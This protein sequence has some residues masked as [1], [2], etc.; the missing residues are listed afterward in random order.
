MDL[1]L[2]SLL[3][4]SPL[5]VI[6][7]ASADYRIVRWSNEATRLFGWT[8]EEAVGK[9]IDELDWIY[10]EDRP[11][12]EQ[13]MADMLSGRR[14]RNVNRNRNVRKDGSVI[15]CEWYNS[16]L[17]DESGAF[18]VLSLVLDVTERKRAEQ[19]LQESERRFRQ[20]FNGMTEGFAL[21]EV[22]CNASATPTDYR[23]LDLN[24]A[25]ERLTG[26]RRDDVIGKTVLE[27]LPGTDPVWIEQ[28]GQVALT[29]QPIH[30]DRYFPP[31]G[32]HYDVFAYSP[33]PRQFAVLFLDIT[34]RKRAEDA[35]RESEERYRA[36]AENSP[37][38]IIRFDRDLRLLFA[39]PATQR[40][41]AKEAV[42]LKG[43]TAQEYGATPASAAAW[44][45]AARRALET[46][47]PQRFDHTSVWG[48]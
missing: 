3:E 34:E 2:E 29:G 19:A 21:H 12:V 18:T 22:V 6:E 24:P 4:N 31:L 1:P 33:A 46:G 44:E 8:A 5:A 39:N 30:F 14:Q 16:T 42:A 41:T 15:H 45:Q 20:L 9:R 43:R 35:L 48:G 40:R 25:F 17:R 36:L 28:Y 27:V 11:L 26:L 37:D 10:P 38:L 13:V 32:K 47:E 7:W 23:F